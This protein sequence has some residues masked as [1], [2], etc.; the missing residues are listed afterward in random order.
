[1]LT[2]FAL[3]YL[4]ASIDSEGSIMIGRQTNRSTF[5]PTISITS[6]SLP[7][8]EYLVSLVDF[9]RI[10]KHNSGSK[11]NW[12]PSWILM[13]QRYRDVALLCKWLAGKLVI[14]AD[15]LVVMTEYIRAHQSYKHWHD[16]TKTHEKVTE[17]EEILYRKL[18]LL[19]AKGVFKQ[20]LGESP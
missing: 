1:M 15:R 9:G 18:R 20:A 7:F 5:R 10:Y 12:S 11:A 3:G 19:N 17:Q 14:K 8:L 4:A 16:K 6:T 2:D 13:W